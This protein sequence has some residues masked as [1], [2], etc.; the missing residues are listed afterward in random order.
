MTIEYITTRNL[1]NSSGQI[2]GK[3]K[4]IK[5]KEEPEATIEYTCPECGFT[6]TKKDVWKKPFSIKCSKCGFLIK[7]SSLKSAIKKERKQT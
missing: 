5:T 4:I 1:E 2:K 3:I 6:E 7:V